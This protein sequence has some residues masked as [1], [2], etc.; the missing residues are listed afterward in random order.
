L[1]T[2]PFDDIGSRTGT[3]GRAS[4]ISTYTPN[5]LNQHS[6][7]TVTNLVVVMGVANPTTNV[8]VRVIGGTTYTAARKGEYYHHA[9]NIGNNVYPQ[10]KAKGRAVYLIHHPTLDTVP[11][12]VSNSS[13]NGGLAQVS[14]FH[15]GRIRTVQVILPG[16]D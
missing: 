14:C 15:D 5:R 10:V 16:V 2:Q 1:Q 7:R 11:L 8:T 12:E 3:G 9:L 4:A 13:L 6:Q